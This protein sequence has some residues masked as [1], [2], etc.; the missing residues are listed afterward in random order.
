MRFGIFT[1]MQRP[2]DKPF[3]TLYDEIMR[4]MVHADEVAFDSYSTIEHHTKSSIR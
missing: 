4:Q 3:A 1:E 2:D